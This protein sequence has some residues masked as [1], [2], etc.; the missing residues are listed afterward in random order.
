MVPGRGMT[1]PRHDSR[2]LNS[3]MAL[4]AIRT[5]SGIPITMP[6]EVSATC[7]SHSR[8]PGA[9]ATER[10]ERRGVALLPAHLGRT[11]TMMSAQALPIS[12]TAGG[13]DTALSSQ[14]DCPRPPPGH[15]LF[16]T[17]QPA[18]RRAAA[19]KCTMGVPERSAPPEP[20]SSTPCATRER[21]LPFATA[22]DR[23]T[24]MAISLLHAKD[25]P[26]VANT[27]FG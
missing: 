10:W 7:V 11:R 5:T 13:T 21:T 14:H 20:G 19:C 18:Q 12:H 2:R 16:P 17:T 1:N 26:C 24:S 27:S 6:R 8:C 3:A 4:Q 25:S 22:G 15:P 9:A 23:S